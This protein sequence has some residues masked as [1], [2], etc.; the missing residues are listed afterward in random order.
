[1]VTERAVHCICGTALDDEAVDFNATV[2][3]PLGTYRNDGLEILR[4]TLIDD[5]HVLADG[6]RAFQLEIG[7]GLHEGHED[8]FGDIVLFELGG[9]KREDEVGFHDLTFNGVFTVVLLHTLVCCRG[10]SLAFPV[11][12]GLADTAHQIGNLPV[13][14]TTE[15]DLHGLVLDSIIEFLTP[16]LA[17]SRGLQLVEEPLL[18]ALVLEHRLCR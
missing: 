7:T 2:Q 4:V 13:T 15:L 16:I 12:K 6:N 1:M 14:E 9:R 5:T 10:N 8:I 18:L 3:G 17:G 11:G